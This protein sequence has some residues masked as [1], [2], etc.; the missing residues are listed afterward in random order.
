MRVWRL[1]FRVSGW[2]LSWLR[3]GQLTGVAL[4]NWARGGWR[5]G[6]YGM[7]FRGGK[8]MGEGEREGEKVVGQLNA[9]VLDTTFKF[10]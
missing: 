7:G 3:G 6:R 5:R 9:G 10:V 8:S 2:R 4:V 1:G